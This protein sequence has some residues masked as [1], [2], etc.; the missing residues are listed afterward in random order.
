M[1]IGL[2]MK[3][4]LFLS[5]YNKKLIYLTNIKKTPISQKPIQW[6]LS[7]SMQVDGWIDRHYEANSLFLQFCKHT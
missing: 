2:H 3:Y 1:Y 7:C 4:S 6:E 5:D